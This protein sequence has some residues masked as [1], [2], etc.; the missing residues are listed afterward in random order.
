MGIAVILFLFS[1]VFLI[2]RIFYVNRIKRNSKIVTI[3]NL[4]GEAQSMIHFIPLRIHNS[5]DAKTRKLK[6]SANIL[7]YIFYAFFLSLIIYGLVIELS[8]FQ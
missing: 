5:E 4:F 7:L 1:L 8:N 6:K 3:L 2:L